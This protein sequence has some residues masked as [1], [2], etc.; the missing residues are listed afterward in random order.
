MKFN[1]LDKTDNVVRINWHRHVIDN[2]KYLYY[3]L[4]SNQ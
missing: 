2:L 3:S 4:F 1:N